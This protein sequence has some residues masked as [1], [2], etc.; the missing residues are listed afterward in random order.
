[1]ESFLSGFSHSYEGTQVGQGYT[2]NVSVSGSAGSVSTQGVDVTQLQPGDTFQGE[3]VSVNGEDVQIQLTNG[4]YMAAKLERDVQVALG[5]F[6]NLQVQSNKDNRVVLKPVYDGRMQMLRVGEAALRAAHMAVSDRNLTLV[7]TLLENGMSINKNTLMLFNRLTLQNPGASMTDLIKLNKLQLPVNDSSLNQLQ[8]YQ[9][10]EHKLLDGIREASDEI[11]KLYDA[12]T[13]KA[14]IQGNQTVSM[15]AVS[16]AAQGTIPGQAALENGGKFMEQV[17]VLL[18]GEE[19]QTGETQAAAN[20]NNSAEVPPE[21][22]NIQE[23]QTVQS[24][25]ET[26]VQDHVGAGAEN[27]S[28]IKGNPQEAAES[29][30]NR[31]TNTDKEAGQPAKQE[32]IPQETQKNVQQNQR[33]LDTILA[34]LKGEKTQALPNKII[35]LMR[36]GSKNGKLEIKDVK[37][38]LMDSDLGKQL[39]AEQKAVIFRSEPFKSMLK[40]GLQKQWTLTPQ[41]LTREGRV[42]EFYQKL[43][44]ESSQLSRMMNEAMQAS[45]QGGSGTQARAMGNI[46]ENVEFMNQMNQVFNYVQLPLKLSNSQAHGDLYVYTN[47][48]NMARKDGMLTAF[49]HL[50]MDNLGALDVSISLQT[51][52]NQV[53]TKFYLDEDSIALVEGHID[54]LAQRLLKKGYQCRNMIL[55]KEEDKTVLEH[56]EEQV[57]GG[58]TVLSYQT[59]DTRA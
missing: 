42:E 4:Q 50:D 5:Q 11:L 48:K 39:T 31:T 18:A 21:G 25:A 54:E 14:D 47:K 8:N 23:G 41:D 22:K 20:G 10:M 24:G 58:S 29:T 51:E 16:D 55:E 9:N 40:N 34:Q 13:G 49:L 28:V 32:A 53:T 15:N 44:K 2:G 37:Q 27:A 43:A 38:L 26:V 36:E 52:R 3:I 6:M 7:S 17:L 59:F 12:L 1:M 56:M 35:S 19:G 33:P 30:S 57:A 46:S 45:G